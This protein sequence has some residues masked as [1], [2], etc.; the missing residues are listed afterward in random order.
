MK[1]FYC[2]F[3]LFLAVGSTFLFAQTPKISLGGGPFLPIILAAV[4][5]P[6]LPFFYSI[7]IHWI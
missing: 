4:A 3:V 5:L 7:K 6:I 2:L 1:K